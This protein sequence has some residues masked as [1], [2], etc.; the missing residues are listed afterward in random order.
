MCRK[1]RTICIQI[2]I[3]C[4]LLGAF[5]RRAYARSVYA[6]SEHGNSTITAYDVNGTT[7]DYETDVEVDWGEGAVGLALDPESE[8]LFVTY[9]RKPPDPL[10]KIELI[11]AKIMEVEQGPATAPGASNLAGI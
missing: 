11:N 9:E 5:S 10:D 2:I 1:I 4:L 3:W 7:M 8:T 6:I